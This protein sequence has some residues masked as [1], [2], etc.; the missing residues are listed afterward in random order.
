MGFCEEHVPLDSLLGFDKGSW[1]YHGDG[2][3]FFSNDCGKYGPQYAQE[4]VVGCR[5]DFDK[6]VAFFTLNG[7]YHGES[8]R[9]KRISDEHL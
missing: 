7:K 6:E 5:V 1:G 8:F 4:D 2:N 9:S 3:A